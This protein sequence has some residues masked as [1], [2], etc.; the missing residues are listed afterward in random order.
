M[1]HDDR[2]NASIWGAI[3]SCTEVG[4]NIFQIVSEKKTGIM[5]PAEDAVNI[6]SEETVAS[7]E[8]AD[9]YVHFAENSAAAVAAKY[10]LVRDGHITDPVA[11]DHFGRPKR[12]EAEARLF[13]PDR[14]GELPDLKRIPSIYG[15]MKEQTPIDNGIFFFQGEADSGIA[16]HD[17]LAEHFM[18]DYARIKH[19]YR[20]DDYRYYELNNTAAIAVF[21]LSSTHP[22]VLDMITSWESL[23]HTLATEFPDYASYWN[24]YVD[25]DAM[26]ADTPAPGFMFLQ[27]HLDAAA[28]STIEFSQEYDKADQMDDF[29]E[30]SIPYDELEI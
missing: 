28:I 5:I 17:V 27:Q 3:L 10:E 29:F 1:N 7:G 4:L 2:P 19:N 11:L 9:G 21:E 30:H 16:V 20:K 12:L 13:L 24:N 18:S 14:F 8:T 26:I 15:E 23:M 22:K 25:Y 6:L